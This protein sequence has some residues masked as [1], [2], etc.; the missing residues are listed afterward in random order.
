MSSFVP[1][2]VLMWRATGAHNGGIVA[3]TDNLGFESAFGVFWNAPNGPLNLLGCRLP[4]HFRKLEPSMAQ[5]VYSMNRVSKTV[6]P[7][8]QILKD[9]S[10][11]FSRAPRLVCWV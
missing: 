2:S 9:I 8:R 1:S 4:A 7:K 6:P 11:S 5:Y 3:W 10:L